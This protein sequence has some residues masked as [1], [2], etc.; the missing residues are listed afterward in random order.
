[1]DQRTRESS[2]SL[3]FAVLTTIALATLGSIAP[4]YGLEPPPL[5]NLDDFFVYNDLGVPEIPADWQLE[6]EGAV[7]T[8]LSLDLEAV[9]QF[10]ATTVMATLECAW[11]TGPLLWVGNGRAPADAAGSGRAPA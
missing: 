5:T 2:A 8:P 9:R 7:E 4:S 10:P 6:V 11:S 1:M 3:T